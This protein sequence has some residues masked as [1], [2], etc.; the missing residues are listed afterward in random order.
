MIQWKDAEA[1]RSDNTTWYVST[2]VKDV[3]VCYSTL[4]SQQWHC[5]SG[6]WSDWETDV[7]SAA[8]CQPYLLGL[9]AMQTRR[10]CHLLWFT[11]CWMSAGFGSL[12][13]HSGSWSCRAAQH[14]KCEQS[15]WSRFLIWCFLNWF[16]VGRSRRDNCS[17]FCAQAFKMLYQSSLRFNLIPIRRYIWSRLDWKHPT[18]QDCFQM[19]CYEIWT[20]FSSWDPKNQCVRN[21]QLCIIPTILDY[22][23]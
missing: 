18:H 4:L 14:N 10:M 12:C 8:H 11:V 19:Q 13:M 7:I 9:I 5:R 22:T 17:L 1:Q 16:N 15:G 21:L 20:F 3:S 23:I 6:W 2:I